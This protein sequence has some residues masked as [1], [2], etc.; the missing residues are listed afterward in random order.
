MMP[1][2]SRALHGAG[3][4]VLLAAIPAT[5]LPAQSASYG[6]LAG[7]V[8]DSAGQPIHGASVRLTDRASRATRGSVT[9]RDGAFRFGV[10]SPAEYDVAVEALGFRPVLYSGVSVSVGGA[11]TLR[12]ALRRERPPVVR[13]DTVRMARGRAAPGSWLFG[14]GY[15]DLVGGRRLASDAAQL[16]SIA[17]DGSVE[18]LPW[19][20]ADL[21]VDGARVGSVGAQG[22]AGSA[23]TALAMPTR[24]LAAVTVGG[25]GFDVE[26]GGSG[27]G[28]NAVSMRGGGTAGLGGAAFGGSADLG[29]ALA[30]GGPIQRDTAHAIIGVDYQRSEISRPA[31]FPLGD[32]EGLAIVDAA[33][34]S[35]G[36]DLSPLLRAGG[37]AE[38]RAS[39]FGRLDWQVDERYA[40]LARIAG[41]RAVL[42]DLPAERGAALPFGA[43]REATAAQASLGVLT[44]I[45]RAF[46][47]EVRVAGD[48][49]DAAA[50]DNVAT[51]FA[52]RGVVVGGTADEAASDQRASLRASGILH[53]AP[54]S[55]RIKLGG[56]V[57]SHRYDLQGEAAGAGAFRF[58]DAL[59][60]AA[61]SGA[62]RG[63][64][65]YGGSGDFRML[66]RAFFVQDAW[67]VT[68]GFAVT[69][70]LRIDGN[71]VPAGDLSANADWLA[72]SGIDNTAVTD[73]R[74][75]VAPRFGFRWEL[76]DARAWVLDGG[77]GVYND[78]PDR[79][80]F[81]QALAFDDGVEVRSAVGSLGAWPL[82]PDAIVAPSRGRTV[83]LLGPGFEGPR[84]RRMSL[85]VQRDVGV[86]TTYL[87]GVY[88]HTDYLA[89]RRD[90][91]LPV[92][93]GSAD[94]FGRPLYGQLQQL[95]SL[96]VAAPGSNRR[97]AGF[98]AATAI[99]ATG[100]SEFTAVTAGVERIV[101]TGLSY[102]AHVTYSRTTDNLASSYDALAPLPLG[103]TG[104]EWSEGTAD[105]D[106][107]LR[108][109]AAAEWS[110][111]PSGALRIG[112]VYRLRSGTPYTPGFRDG[113]DANGDG[114]AGNDPAWIDGSV[115][116]IQDLIDA[117]DCLAGA[118]GAYAERNS[119]RGDWTHRLDLRAAFRLANL[120]GG[121]LDLV[122]DAIDALP[123]SSGR[124]DRA[125]YLVDRTGTLTTNTITGV[126]TVPLVV[127]P[128][129]GELV[130]DRSAGVLFR[131]GLRIGR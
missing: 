31:R 33:R 52:G 20:F 77:A 14:R 39:G 121:P 32:A 123:G 61:G 85:G 86:W 17:D 130:D 73:S 71:R 43:R 100:F 128:N 118:A 120:A 24:A 41:S 1:A 23:T 109:I 6:S 11:S 76:G 29:G 90:L 96:L 56:I 21:M 122:I 105:T 74:V 57:A 126:T 67:T 16:S 46:A 69:L 84:T 19:R 47:A 65:P 92:T 66:E 49:G 38:E 114:V 83:A 27:V 70:G 94:Q 22:V 75:R 95:G 108:L 42:R 25:T 103:P 18:G 119:C 4:A 58:G 127:N 45:S 87:R 112:L 80:D 12:I 3:L 30:L 93:P 113:V 28:L 68:D 97:F 78:L 7:V 117:Q 13:I 55:H 82:A 5:R 102:G 59:D 63:L 124:I 129:F 37:L 98:D 44:R 9:V 50:D 107:P 104:R 101:P 115:P 81:G 15:S 64:A 26:V 111:T 88:R 89:R 48:V 106:A 36:T 35:H 8:V 79:G 110:V 40:I 2:L 54:P 34:D 99:E 62:W 60:F 116:G 10:L 91:N 53:W 125:L 131:V 72:V 51:A